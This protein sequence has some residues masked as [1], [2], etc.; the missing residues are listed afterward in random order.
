M[1]EPRRATRLAGADEGSA[2]PVPTG[3]AGRCHRE[4]GS[5]VLSERGQTSKQRSWPISSSAWSTG[6]PTLQDFRAGLLHHL[7]IRDALSPAGSL[8]RVAVRCGGQAERVT[9]SPSGLANPEAVAAARTEWL[10]QRVAE[11]EAVHHRARY[12]EAGCCACTATPRRTA[13]TTSSCLRYSS[14]SSSSCRPSASCHAE[15][16]A[17]RYLTG[18]R[19]S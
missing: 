12:G 10:A 5:G 14:S 11:Q 15:L 1:A 4:R 7:T 16:V 17:L 19:G 13:S 3:R 6:S 8:G 18:R 9:V 2:H